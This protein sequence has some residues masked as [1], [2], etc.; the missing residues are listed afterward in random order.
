MLKSVSYRTL[1]RIETR[2]HYLYGDQ[3]PQLASRL[4]MMIGRY[5]VGIKGAHAVDHREWDQSDIALIT[6][7]DMIRSETEAPLRALHRFLRDHIGTAIKTVHL[8]P[9]FPYSSDDGFSVINYRTVDPALG[10]WRDIEKMHADYALMFDLVINHVSRQSSW[11]KDYVSDI[12]PYR[13]FFHEVDPATD[14]SAVVRPRNL[15]LLTETQTRTGRKHLWA[16]FSADQIDINFGNPEVLFEY[17]DILMWY[18]AKGARII[19]LDAIAY[20]WKS[21]GTPCIHLT[22]THEI[23]KLLRA[24][25]GM[26]APGVWLLTETNVPHDE[27]MSYFGHHDE[28]HMVYQFSLPPL[29][30]HGLLNEY[31]G[32]LTRWAA[33]LPNLPPGQTFFNFTA[34]HD[35]VGVRPLHGLIGEDELNQLIAHVE[36]MGGR[37]SYKRNADGSES[38]YELNITYF[39]L[40]A[41]D[42]HHV[43][44]G[45]LAR[46]LS[47]QAIMLALRGMPAIYINSLFGARNDQDGVDESGHNRRI[48]RQ[49]WTAAELDTRL[50]APDAHHATVFSAYRHLLELRRT[51]TAFH[52]DGHQHIHDA[53]DAV[54]ALERTAPDGSQRILCLTNFTRH[55][56]HINPLAHPAAP[57]DLIAGHPIPCTDGRWHLQPYQTCWLHVEPTP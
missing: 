40:L 27:N 42:Q 11:F 17:L 6:Y 19:R 1:E 30:A 32:H 33:G 13:N 29:L 36:H 50:N 57:H 26:I 16:T 22:Q 51:Q 10:N 4:F 14:L 9:F 54:F 21:V 15:P 25:L 7:G 20:L 35:G 31:A 8:L 53:G 44:P 24:F 45:H 48:N 34:S 18:I 37:V 47:S 12:A 49:K 39:D 28:A 41:E 56:Q 23:V 5:G 2:L 55:E 3:A 38:P 52:P 43:T 46:F